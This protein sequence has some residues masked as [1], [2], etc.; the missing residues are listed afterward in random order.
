MEKRSPD[1]FRAKTQAIEVP[2]EKV[3]MV[4]ANDF[5]FRHSRRCL[6][7]TLECDRLDLSS[8]RVFGLRIGF[9]MANQ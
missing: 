1:R 7:H 4:F 5:K 2:I 8:T 6:R 3:N 9:Q